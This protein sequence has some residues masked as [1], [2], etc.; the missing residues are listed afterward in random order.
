M[1]S[2]LPVFMSV[3]IIFLPLLLF[4]E[5][6]GLYLII[7]SVILL[8]LSLEGILYLL[9]SSKNKELKD[10]MDKI[11]SEF[12]SIVSLNLRKLEMGFKTAKFIFIA[13]FVIIVLYILE[14]N[15]AVTVLSVFVLFFSIVELKNFRSK[16]IRLITFISGIINILYLASVAVTRYII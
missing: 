15:P 3:V 12:E 6:T 7:S 11:R 16:K 2:K 9:E 5:N 13:T 1:G 10:E 4:A 14:L 8:V